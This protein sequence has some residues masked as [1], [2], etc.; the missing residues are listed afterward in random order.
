MNQSEEPCCLSLVGR[1]TSYLKH[2]T[3]DHCHPLHFF[4]RTPCMLVSLC[5][6]R[7]LWRVVQY[8]SRPVSHLRMQLTQVIR[9]GHEL[10]L[11]LHFVMAYDMQRRSRTFGYPVNNAAS[12]K[13]EVY[14]I[15]PVMI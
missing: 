14:V 12:S 7:C 9:C 1:I 8:T 6:G 3:I 5:L 11:F 2:C 4:V 10:Q 13:R 15:I